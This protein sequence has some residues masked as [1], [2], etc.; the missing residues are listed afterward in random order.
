VG[1]ISTNTMMISVKLVLKVLG[2]GEKGSDIEI[3]KRKTDAVTANLL[4]FTER[5]RP[6]LVQVGSAARVEGMK[7][8]TTGLTE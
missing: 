3:E 7:G 2:T 1:E 5:A 8:W 4:D 6:V